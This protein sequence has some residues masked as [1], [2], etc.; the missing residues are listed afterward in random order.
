VEEPDRLG[1]SAVLGAHPELEVGLLPAPALDC[2]A[3]ELADAGLVD[4]G[5][6]G[7]SLNAAT[8]SSSAAV[9]TP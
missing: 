8:E 1:I 3:D 7:A 5:E 9:T 4:C 6:R 2:G